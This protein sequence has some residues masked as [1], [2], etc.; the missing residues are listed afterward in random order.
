MMRDAVREGATLKLSGDSDRPGELEVFADQQVKNLFWN[1]RLAKSTTTTPVRLPRDRDRRPEAG[2]PARAHDL[3]AHRR[4]ARGRRRPSTTR[5]GRSRTTSPRRTPRSPRRCRCSTPTTTASTTA[6]RGTAATS[7]APATSR[8]SRCAP[9]PARR[10]SWAVWLNGH[11]LGTVRT[12]SATQESTKDFTFP[13]DLVDAGRRQRGLGAGPQ[14]GPQRGRRQQRR[15]QEPARPAVGVDDRLA[16]ARPPGGSRA[17]AAA[18]TSSTR[19]AASANN[20]GLHGER[21]GYPLPGYPDRRRGTPSPPRR[22]RD[23]PG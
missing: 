5:P 14:H 18:R 23:S 8:A 9:A 1:G 6:T 10:A 16:A 20:G 4:P 17:P 13:A 11:Y 3:E 15:A 22:P 19:R 21:A 2:R 7:P 12:R